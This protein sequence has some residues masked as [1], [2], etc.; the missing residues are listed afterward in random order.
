[1]RLLIR[2]PVLAIDVLSHSD[3]TVNQQVAEI[4]ETF[5]WE[6]LPASFGFNCRGQDF[7]QLTLQVSP[8]AHAAFTKY[9]ADRGKS[10]TLAVSQALIMLGRYR[11]PR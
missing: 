6:S 11:P 10:Q 5:F 8:N 2:V 7:K 9:C 1:M 3:R 4:I